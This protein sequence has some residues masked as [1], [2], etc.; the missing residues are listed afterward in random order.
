MRSRKYRSSSAL[1][2][3]AALMSASIRE[4]SSA[5]VRAAACSRNQA[6]SLTG[7][8]SSVQ[9]T[10]MG[11]GYANSVIRSSGVPSRPISRR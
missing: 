10:R 11:S 9:M 4:G 5:M 6:E 7:T 2:P 3:S 1:A 8:P